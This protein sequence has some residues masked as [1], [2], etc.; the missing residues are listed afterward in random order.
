M[1][2]KRM[3]TMKIVDSDAFLDMPVST[4]CLYFHL[5]MRADDDGFVGNP[6]RIMKLVGGTED[7]I[8]VLIAKRFVLAMEDGVLVIKHWRMHNTIQNDRYVPT[9]Y[10]DQ[11]SQ[12]VLKPNKAYTLA[13]AMAGVETKCIQNVSADLDIDSDIDIDI[14]NKSRRFTPPTLTEIEAYIT[15]NDL[16][17]V[18]AERF[19]TFYESNGWKVGQNK[20]KNW[21]AALSGWNAREKP[22]TKPKEPDTEYP[23]ISIEDLHKLVADIGKAGK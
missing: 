11:L 20:M 21:R 9:T 14:D 10:Q 3:F 12:L 7:D 5:C 13:D 6:K 23:D 16:Q 1:A 18:N 2:N 22:K 4:Q 19:Y 15:E 17:Y 8:R